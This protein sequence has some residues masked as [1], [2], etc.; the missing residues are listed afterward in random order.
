MFFGQI[1]CRLNFLTFLIIL[2]HLSH[3]I[4]L[5]NFF[6]C[7]FCYLNLIFNIKYYIESSQFSELPS[8]FN[9]VISIEFWT[10]HLLYFMDFMQLN[11]SKDPPY[12]Y[13]PIFYFVFTPLLFTFLLS[14]C[15]SNN[16]KI[17][18]SLKRSKYQPQTKKKSFLNKI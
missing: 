1:T 18:L 11:S 10:N 12:F 7:R 8:I 15:N 6:S 17:I 2:I 3:I 5:K 13:I 14:E 16:R 9:S 4:F